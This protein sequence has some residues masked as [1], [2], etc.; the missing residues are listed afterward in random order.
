MTLH[1]HT[2]IELTDVHTGAVEV[3]ESDNLITNAVSDIFNGYGGSLNKAMLL[4]RGDQGY[5]NAPKDLVTMF[6]GGLLLYDTPLGSDPATVFAPAGAGVVGTAMAGQVNATKNTVRGS[7]NLT[8]TK[9]DPWSGVVT[10]VYEFATSQANGVISS[11][12]LTHPMGAYYSEMIDAPDAAACNADRLGFGGALGG[13]QLLTGLLAK[14]TYPTDEK[15]VLLY[16]DP[17]A[18]EAVAGY[19]NA[20]EGMLELRHHALGL[21]TLDLFRRDP[22]GLW[23]SLRSTD[24]LDVGDF[25]QVDSSAGEDYCRICFDAEADKIYLVSAPEVDYVDAM[26]VVKIRE[27]DRKT[28]AAKDYTV[29]NN[30]GVDLQSFI[31]ENRGTPLNGTVYGG[32][33]YMVED[34][35]EQIYR[36]PLADPTD[37]Q[38]VTMHGDDMAYLSDAHDGRLYC[39]YR[40]RAVVLN[41]GKNELFSC[42]AAGYDNTT[43]GFSTT[44]PVL[45]EPCA[46]GKLSGDDQRPAE[47]GGKDRRQDDEGHLH[48]AQRRLR[49]QQ[50]GIFAGRTEVRCPYARWGWTRGGG[51]VWHGGLDLAGLDDATIRMPYYKGKRITGRVTRA[52]IVTDRRDKTWEWGYYVCVQLDRGQT[53]DAVNFLYFAHCSSLLVKAGQRVASGDALAVMGNTGNAALAD[54]PYR[55]CHLEVRAAAGGVGLDPTVYAGCENAVGVYGAAGRMQVITVGPVTQGDADAVL[56]VCRARGLVDAGLYRSEWRDA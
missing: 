54:P 47:V 14:T 20:D 53:P 11:V 37:V 8:E 2:R 39:Y 15:G 1:G 51:K 56:E 12:C 25:L 10:Y 42:E 26:G 41:T 27:Y 7:A 32:S 19:L 55:H 33:L 30:T 34:Q 6:Y 52:R 16:A 5:T 4:W 49:M 38:A 45:G 50:T 18:D 13:D 43:S 17:E 44:A 22:T 23:D 21:K 29:P 48:P 35:A 3:V 40:T 28:L 31:S 36:F 46:A 24:T 9:I